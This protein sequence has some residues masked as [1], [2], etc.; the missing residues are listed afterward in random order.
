MQDKAKTW[1]TGKKKRALVYKPFQKGKPYGKGT[2]RRSLRIFCYFFLFLFIYFI[3]GPALQ[4]ENQTLRII[5]NVMLVALGGMLLYVD[6]ARQGEEDVML[7]ETALNRI[8]S[9]RQVKKE[10]IARCYHPWKAA[11][12]ALIGC[13]PILMITIPFALTAEKQ[14]YSLQPLPEWLNAL[15][16]GYEDIAQPLSYYNTSV[17]ITIV[18]FIRMVVRALNLPFISIANIF[19]A[20]AVLLVDRLAPVLICLPVIGYPIGYLTGPR[21]RALIHGDI[22]TS[23]KRHARKERQAAR[24]RRERSQKNNQII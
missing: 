10:E 3:L 22:S 8:E 6:G 16:E 1:K 18:D 20:D 7:G 9:G 14:S 21:A 13:L 15:R 4:F 11:I 5:T 19:G 23:K 24:A 17:A 12:A 2:I